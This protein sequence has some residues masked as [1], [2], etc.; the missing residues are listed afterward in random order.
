[1]NA[2]ISDTIKVCRLLCILFMT[3]VHVNPGSD[4]WGPEAPQHLQWAGFIMSDILGRASVPALSLIGGF[5]AVK[6]INSRSSWYAYA[7][8]RAITIIIPAITWNI[9]IVTVSIL[10]FLITQSETYIIRELNKIENHTPWLIIDKLTGYNYGSITMAFNFLRDIF[11]CS[12]LLPILLPLI[13]NG[14]V[15]AIITI[16]IIGLTIGYAP[17]IF[18]PHILMFFSLG[19]FIHFQIKN[20]ASIQRT[21]INSLLA[22]G[23]SLSII[24]IAKKIGLV[25]VNLEGTILRVTVA[26]LIIGLCYLMV[27]TK[28]IRTIIKAEPAAFLLFLSHQTVMLILWGGWQILFGN[29]ITEKYI[30]FYMVAPIIS[31]TLAIFFH[32]IT[33]KAPSKVKSAIRGK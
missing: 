17:I 11:I 30:V 21:I 5:L 14:G 3:Y 9:I 19:V 18:R 8:D 23:A 16:W 32:K 10:I 25:D 13:R 33:N 31:L 29:Q 28:F 12:L 7:K 20:L 2:Q 26:T 27:D 24:Y 22:V 4:S 1:M 15:L 6:A